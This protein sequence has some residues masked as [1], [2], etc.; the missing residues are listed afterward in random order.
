MVDS[1]FHTVSN[2]TFLIYSISN[3]DSKME[4][5]RD[6]LRNGKYNNFVA[7]YKMVSNIFIQNGIQISMTKTDFFKKSNI[8]PVKCDT[9]N[10]RLRDYN[11]CIFY[12]KNDTLKH[13][14]KIILEL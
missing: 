1:S 4:I 5:Y 6:D 14:E 2:D 7:T 13:I 11:S 12:F 9:F 3:K 10:I 8:K